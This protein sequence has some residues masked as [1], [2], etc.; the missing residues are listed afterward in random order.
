MVCLYALYL[1]MNLVYEEGQ[2]K[3]ILSL[4]VPRPTAI[5]SP[6]PRDPTEAHLS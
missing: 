6:V 1:S 2:T 4:S 5:L 3:T